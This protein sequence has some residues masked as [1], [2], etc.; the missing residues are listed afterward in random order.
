MLSSQA[1]A[2]LAR[3]EREFGAKARKGALELLLGLTRINDEG[4]TRQRISRDG[5]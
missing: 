4:A 1:D 3:I 2:L 5:R